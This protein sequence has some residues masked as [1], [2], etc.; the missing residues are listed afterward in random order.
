MRLQAASQ[1]LVRGGSQSSPTSSVPLPHAS[2]AQR[3]EQPSPS[4]VLPSSQAS[5]ALIVRSPQRSSW[6]M[7]RALHTL[8]FGGSQYSPGSSRPLPQTSSSQPPLQPS[9]SKVLPSSH[10]SPVSCTELP[11]T[12]RREAAGMGWQR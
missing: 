12:P 3:D 4:L 5:P 10:S 8:V 9:A 11:H 1:M 2:R 6:G 7:H